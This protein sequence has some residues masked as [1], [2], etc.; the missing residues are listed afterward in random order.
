MVVAVVVEIDCCP[1]GVSLPLDEL[2]FAADDGAG[3]SP[4]LSQARGRGIHELVRVVSVSSHSASSTCLYF[5]ALDLAL[6]QDLRRE[7][8]LVNSLNS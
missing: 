3:V 4:P 8:V 2:R 5:R 6:Q 7:A 1:L